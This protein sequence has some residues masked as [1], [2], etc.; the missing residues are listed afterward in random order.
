M[1]SSAPQPETM[2]EKQDWFET[3][4]QVVVRALLAV[5]LVVAYIAFLA[6]DVNV[7]EFFTGLVGLA[8][9]FFVGGA[10]QRR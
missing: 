3:R 7:P 1:S 5:V 10:V 2:E 8:A 4:T 6:F 9:G